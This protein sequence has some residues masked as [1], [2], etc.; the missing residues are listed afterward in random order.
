M[1]KTP[2]ILTT[3]RLNLRPFTLADAER[4]R[5]LA[6]DRA[7]ADMTLNVPHP[8]E[9]GMAEAWIATHQPGFER[10]ELLA[11]AMAFPDQE[12]II[13][14]LGLRLFLDHDRATLGY[15]VG[16][17]YWG[18]GYCTEAARALVAYGFATLGLNK[19]SAECLTR[20]PASARVL[21]KLGMTHEGHKR[22]HY[23]KWDGFDDVEE[24]GLLRADACA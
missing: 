11:L 4:V 19:I 9:V 20:N 3:D 8:Y 23:R 13:G 24:Y 2:P 15:W 6:G 16:R 10:D 21:V 5:L 7:I 1:S 17:D 14:A 12:Q 18:Q 22:Q